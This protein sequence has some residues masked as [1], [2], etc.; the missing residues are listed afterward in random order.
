MR[1]WMR[2][3]PNRWNPMTVRRGPWRSEGDAMLEAQVAR[4]PTGRASRVRAATMPL[5]V[6]LVAGIVLVLIF[7]RLVNLD[8]VYQRL[9]HLSI[10]PALLCGLA[11]LG[12]YTVRAL[13]WRWLL[14][15]Y[16]V[17]IPRVVSVYLVAI[18]INW[19]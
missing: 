14:K 3:G 13:R 2:P 18:F 8:A 9:E 16:N 7:L 6:G 17:G 11:F 12:A 1:V 10:G 19:L 15:P 5:A 4:P